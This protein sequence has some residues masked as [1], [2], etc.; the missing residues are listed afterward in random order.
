M[1]LLDLLAPQ[2]LVDLAVLRVLPVL[3]APED[4]YIFPLVH[5]LVFKCNSSY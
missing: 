2:V 4:N 5:L 3:E 1:A